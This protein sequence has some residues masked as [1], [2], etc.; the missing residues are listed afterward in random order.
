[1]SVNVLYLITRQ[2]SISSTLVQEGVL[3]SFDCWF[4]ECLRC[5]KNEGDRLASWISRKSKMA[6]KN[7]SISYNNNNNEIYIV[8]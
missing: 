4:C 3:W 8:F 2:L 1:M 7:E 5:K 6:A